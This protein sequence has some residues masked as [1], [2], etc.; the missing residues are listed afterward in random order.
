MPAPEP[1]TPV[2]TVLGTGRVLVAPDAAVLSLGI[3]SR[4]ENPAEA[5]ERCSALTESVVEQL[6]SL[7]TRVQ[8]RQL[9]VGPEFDH[10]PEGRRLLGYS[11]QADLTVHVAELARAGAVAAAAVGAAGA[12]GLVHG[13]RLVLGDS[14]RAEA[15][16]RDAAFRDAQARA[17]RYASLAGRR[18]GGLLELTEAE[19]PSG[20]L[21][22][23]GSRPLARAL[24][25]AAMPVEAG[26]SEV[27]ACVVATWQLAEQAASH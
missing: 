11:A 5:L 25:A 8:S 24:A 15:E 19:A 4:G 27:V 9:S 12:A 16:A 13:L 17:A 10:G 26:E 14:E 20:L 2:V 6:G 18:L 21:K 23:S 22:S 7:P 3:Q 1:P